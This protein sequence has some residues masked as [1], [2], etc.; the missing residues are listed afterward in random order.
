[1]LKNFVPAPT[2]RQSTVYH[3]RCTQPTLCILLN[4]S[5]YSCALYKLLYVHKGR[6]NVWLGE[7]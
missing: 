3:L 4:F 7:L 1:M 2:P 5:C 6:E